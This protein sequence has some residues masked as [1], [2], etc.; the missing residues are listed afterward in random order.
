MEAMLDRIER[1]H[2]SITGY[3]TDIGLAVSDIEALRDRLLASG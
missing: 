3:L 2:G 1:R